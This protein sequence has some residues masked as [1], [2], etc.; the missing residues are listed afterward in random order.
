VTV[1][2]WDYSVSPPI[3]V[4]VDLDGNGTTDTDAQEAGA[5]LRRPIYEFVIDA[6]VD[7][8]C[9]VANTDP[10]AADPNMRHWLCYRTASLFP[11]GHITTPILV[12]QDLGDPLIGAG[13]PAYGE[14]VRTM[15]SSL[16][17]NFSYFGPRCDRHETLSVSRYFKRDRVIDAAGRQV[18]YHVAVQEFIAG[19][20]TSIYFDPG[21]TFRACA[22]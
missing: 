13:I 20:Y 8:S 5:P 11:D 12:K 1:K 14:G 18:S 4:E 10:F 9:R 21:V 22:P 19:V 7:Q 16:P 3:L 15:M 6:F 2:E 17:S